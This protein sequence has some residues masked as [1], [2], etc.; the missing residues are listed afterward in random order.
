M[1][2]VPA[3]QLDGVVLLE[4]ELMQHDERGFF[5]VLNCP[6]GGLNSRYV[7]ARSARGVIRGMHIR[8]GL[9]EAKLVRCSA[10]VAFDVIVDLREGSPTCGDWAGIYLRGDRQAG[11]YIPPGCAHGYQA[12]QDDTD[13]SYRIDGP[14]GPREDIAFAWNDREL[15]IDWPLPP[16]IMSGRDRDAPPLHEAVTW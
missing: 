10:G 16:G 5:C 6:G 2:R 9:G 14:P 11:V 4:P 1:T 12:L 15:G 7:I 3:S 8:P 13:M